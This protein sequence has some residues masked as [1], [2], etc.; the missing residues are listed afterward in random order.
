MTTVVCGVSLA[1]VDVSIRVVI[2]INLSVCLR[3]TGCVSKDSEHV[4]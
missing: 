2:H 3:F 4:L 1:A